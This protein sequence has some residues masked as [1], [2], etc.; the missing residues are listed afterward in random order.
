[1]VAATSRHDHL[2]GNAF[3]AGSFHPSPFLSRLLDEVLVSSFLR[4]NVLEPLL[5]DG[6]GIAVLA[7]LIHLSD[8]PPITEKQLGQSLYTL[9]VSR[10][11]NTCLICGKPKA[12]LERALGCVR[13]HLGQKPF[14]CVGCGL[15]TATGE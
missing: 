4:S 11:E 8:F 3:D 6:D 9:F 13:A 7:D 1:M 2:L 14:G 10:E 12:S 5:G 15:C